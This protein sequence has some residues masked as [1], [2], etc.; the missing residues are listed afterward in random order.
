VALTEPDIQ[1][2]IGIKQPE[3]EGDRP[4]P[5]SADSRVCRPLPPASYQLG[6]RITG[7]SLNFVL[8]NSVRLASLPVILRVHFENYVDI[9]NLRQFLLV[10]ILQ[11]QWKAWTLCDLV[12]TLICVASDTAG[13]FWCTLLN[14]NSF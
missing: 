2:E 7:A 11:K 3:R 9:H 1:W 13:K 10:L 5:L 6:A 12:R 14:L 8:F 4:P